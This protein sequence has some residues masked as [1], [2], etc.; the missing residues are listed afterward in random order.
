[1]S[2]QAVKISEGLKALKRSYSS[3]YSYK[4]SLYR[5][6]VE[7]E[8]REFKSVA[9]VLP[10]SNGDAVFADKSSLLG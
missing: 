2:L 4:K 5:L 1:M 9:L 10:D 7:I 6:S 8:L 3:F